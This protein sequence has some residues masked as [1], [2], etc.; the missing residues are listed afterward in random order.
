MRAD[1]PYGEL[2]VFQPKTAV[3]DEVDCNCGGYLVCVWRLKNI[4]CLA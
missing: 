3:W 1:D 2:Q 4:F